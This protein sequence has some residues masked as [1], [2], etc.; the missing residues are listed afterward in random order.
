MAGGVSLWQALTAYKLRYPTTMTK[1]NFLAFVI[2][3]CLTCTASAQA[4]FDKFQYELKVERAGLEAQM[5]YLEHPENF[6]DCL[7]KPLGVMQGHYKDFSKLVKKKEKRDLLKSHYIALVSQMK[8]VEPESGE[9]KIVYQRRQSEL[10]R[11]TKE[12]WMQFDL[13]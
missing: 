3:A 8:G 12:A 7:S 11:R 13:D 9:L 2:A 6:E 4:P 10:K 5:C 1:K